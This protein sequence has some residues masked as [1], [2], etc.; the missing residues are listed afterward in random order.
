MRIGMSG[1]KL[2]LELRAN[3]GSVAPMV[4][5]LA[6]ASLILTTQAG[7][8]SLNRFM[9]KSSPQLDTS[10][11]EAQGFS[12]PPGGMPTAVDAGSSGEPSVVLEI[13][14][15]GNERHVERI[16]LPMDKGVFVEDIVQQAKLH[17]HLGNLNI[18]IMRPN[19][20]AGSPPIR[21]DLRT[22]SKGRAHSVGSNYALFPGDHLVVIEDQRSM[23]ER[24]IA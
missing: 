20:T 16:P 21:L 10:L 24:F 3:R 23:L 15:G 8:L 18:S 5:G 22:D 13:R 17:E 1:I 2:G 11:L 4:L 12:V 19:Q 9:R 14:R 7:C 6:M